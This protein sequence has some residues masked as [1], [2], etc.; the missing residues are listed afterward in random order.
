M[1]NLPRSEMSSGSEHVTAAETAKMGE[2]QDGP[3]IKLT[4]SV[5]T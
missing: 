2:R 4:E 1:E 5:D 3:G